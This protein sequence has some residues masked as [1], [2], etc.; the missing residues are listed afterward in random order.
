PTAWACLALRRAGYGEQAR[1]HEGLE[2]LLDRCLP[3]GGINYGNRSVFGRPLEPIV[4]PT[5]LMLLA[6]QRRDDDTRVAKSIDYLCRQAV[7]T[8]DLEH[9]C[10]ARLVLDV[11]QKQAQD[12]LATR[13]QH[14]V[15]DV[16]SR[17]EAA[18]ALRRDTPYLKDS[19]I[20]AAL[21]ALAL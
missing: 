1:V 10:W 9:L 12:D 19:P 18:H 21:A 7:S 20:R 4:T 2:L 15:A 11:Y 14:V 13:L 3:D 16:G 8:D 5:A 17:I 6:L